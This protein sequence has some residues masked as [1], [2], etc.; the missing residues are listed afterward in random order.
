MSQPHEC[1]LI[2]IQKVRRLCVVGQRKIR[3]YT[4]HEAGD[5]FNNHDPAPATHTMQAIHVA[6]AISQ[7]TAKSTGNSSA[8]EEI[9]H[10]KRKFSLGVEESKIHSQPRE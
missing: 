5:A 1:L 4:D 10:A 2:I 6:N 8:D 3:D 7:Q 9:A